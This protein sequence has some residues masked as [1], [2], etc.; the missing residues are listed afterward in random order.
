MSYDEH[1]ISMAGGDGE[2]LTHD[3]IAILA[4]LTMQ[5]DAFFPEL[6]PKLLKMKAALEVTK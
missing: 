2:A 3:E 4:I 6:G 5:V 1:L